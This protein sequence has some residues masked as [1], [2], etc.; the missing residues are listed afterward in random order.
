MRGLGDVASAARLCRALDARAPVLSG[1]YYDEATCFSGATMRDGS[2]T[3]GTVEGYGAVGLTKTRV[4]ARS[5]Q[6]VLLLPVVSVLTFLLAQLLLS[7]LFVSLFMLLQS[8]FKRYH[9]ALR[10][11]YVTP[12]L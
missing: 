5:D 12:G 10:S 7:T 1:P 4:K 9:F 3:I 6:H 11:N 2:P 8:A